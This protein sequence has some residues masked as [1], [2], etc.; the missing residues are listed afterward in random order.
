M[1]VKVYRLQQIRLPRIVL[2]SN[3]VYPLE[4]IKFEGLKVL[5]IL[6]TDFLDHTLS[7]YHFS[8][9]CTAGAGGYQ[10]VH[11][12]PFGQISFVKNHHRILVVAAK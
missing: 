10:N 8:N 1:D 7:V 2:T 6:N 5:V 3:Q 11:I 4:A 9:Q 12:L